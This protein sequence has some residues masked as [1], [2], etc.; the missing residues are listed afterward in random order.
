L[1]SYS[2]RDIGGTV[3]RSKYGR[4]NRL[5]NWELIKYAKRE[6]LVEYDRG[7]FA[8]GQLGEELKGINEF[9]LSIGGTVCEKFS[10]SKNYAKSFSASKFLYLTA[11]STKEKIK[12]IV[13]RQKEKSKTEKKEERLCCKTLNQF[14]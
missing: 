13:K 1:V 7:G 8:I 11:I 9:K 6:G 5:G 10:Y 4:G 3:S 14:F 12:A 2:N